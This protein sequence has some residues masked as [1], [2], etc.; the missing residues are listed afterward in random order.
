M[1]SRHRQG[2]KGKRQADELDNLSFLQDQR[3]S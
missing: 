1:A 2:D 3:F